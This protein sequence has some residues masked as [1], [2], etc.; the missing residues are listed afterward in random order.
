MPENDSRKPK[1]LSLSGRAISGPGT[2]SGTL[3]VIPAARIEVEP[4]ETLKY[5]RLRVGDIEVP[6]RVFIVQDGQRR[7]ITMDSLPD[8]GGE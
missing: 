2:T 6:N 5:L 3:S 1:R 8:E 4:S 7:E